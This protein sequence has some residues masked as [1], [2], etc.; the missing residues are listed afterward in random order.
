M[1]VLMNE[2]REYLRKPRGFFLIYFSTKLFIIP[3]VSYFIVFFFFLLI[4]Y[5]LLQTMSHEEIVNGSLE[6]R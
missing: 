1:N 4:K 6:T 2:S 5:L 3:V